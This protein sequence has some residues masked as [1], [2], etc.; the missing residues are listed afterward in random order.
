MKPLVI[1]VVVSAI[2]V[3]VS[4]VR[5]QAP[6]QDPP[7]APGGRR[8][9]GRRRGRRR[10]PARTEFPSADASARVRGGAR[11]RQGRLRRQLHRVPRR[12]PSRR[13]SGRTQPSPL[14]GCI[15]RPARGGD[16]ADCA[17]LPPGQGYAR[18]QPGR[19]R[20]HRG[21]RV[22]PQHSRQ[23]G[24]A[25]ASAGGHRPLESQHTGR[26]SVGGRGVLQE[27]M[28]EL[29]FDHRRSQRHR[30]AVR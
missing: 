30:R 23:G 12:R 8:G 15:E 4:P 10:R 5:A 7:P 28:R 27:Q 20:Y 24:L 29:P 6:G 14:A 18:L 26:Q 3:G 16:W 25:G 9:A 22:H 19:C 11:A 17:R 2:A 1:V 13:R 21:L